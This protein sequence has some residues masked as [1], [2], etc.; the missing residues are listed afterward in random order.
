MGFLSRSRPPLA[1]RFRPPLT[2][3]PLHS[4]PPHVESKRVRGS[5]A[6]SS[7]GGDRDRRSERRACGC[8]A[9]PTGIRRRQSFYPA[10]AASSPIRHSPAGIM[11][12]IHRVRLRFAFDLII[13]SPF[14]AFSAPAPSSHRLRLEQQGRDCGMPAH[15]SRK[16]ANNRHGA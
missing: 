16:P 2:L 12:I 10:P 1:L 8:R 7:R 15:A 14:T 4:F 11:I 5:S 3:L 6:T 13:T 9:S